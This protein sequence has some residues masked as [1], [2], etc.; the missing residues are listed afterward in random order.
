MGRVGCEQCQMPARGAAHQHDAAGVEGE[1]VRLA[2]EIGD[3]GVYIVELRGELMLWRKSVGDRCDRVAV[4]SKAPTQLRK[5]RW[6]PTAPAPTM[7]NDH[8]WR[9]SSRR[10]WRVKVDVDR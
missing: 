7:Q 4:F 2:F 9:S 5:L 3:C 10:Q 8:E 6:V 1:D